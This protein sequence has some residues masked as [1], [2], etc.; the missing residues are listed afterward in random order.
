MDFVSSYGKS[1][2]TTAEFEFR[3]AVFAE[4]L[5]EIEE[6]NSQEGMTSIHGINMFTDKTQDEIKSMLGFKKMDAEEKVN[7]QDFSTENL[8]DSI[9][10]RTQGAVTGVKD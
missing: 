3:K 10:W 4:R 8:A 7:F 2:G 5:Q 9:D 1:Y 6:L